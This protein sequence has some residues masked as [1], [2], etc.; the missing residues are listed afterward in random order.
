MS[1]VW[2]RDLVLGRRGCALLHNPYSPKIDSDDGIIKVYP[3]IQGSFLGSAKWQYN[4]Y[5]KENFVSNET[6]SIYENAPPN[7]IQKIKVG[8]VTYGSGANEKNPFIFFSLTNKSIVK[9]S[10]AT[11]DYSY[12]IQGRNDY[13][14]GWHDLWIGGYNSYNLKLYGKADYLYDYTPYGAQG[15]YLDPKTIPAVNSNPDWYNFKPVENQKV[16]QCYNAYAQ[17]N[18]LQPG[19]PGSSSWWIFEQNLYYVP[20]IQNENGQITNLGQCGFNVS[21]VRDSPETQIGNYDGSN[22]GWFKYANANSA[23]GMTQITS[24]ERAVLP[25]GYFYYV[26]PVWCSQS[27][28]QYNSSNIP[29]DLTF[30][31]P[32]FGFPFIMLRDANDDTQNEFDISYNSFITETSQFT[33]REGVS[34]SNAYNGAYTAFRTPNNETPYLMR[35]QIVKFDLNANLA[36]GCYDACWHKN[37]VIKIKLKYQLGEISINKKA[38]ELMAANEI[39]VGFSINYNWT[40]FVEE[41]V[42]NIEIQFDGENNNNFFTKAIWSKEIECSPGQAKRLVDICVLEVRDKT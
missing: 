30:P 19:Y 3:Y 35:N 17:P 34:P 4:D 2:F 37:K 31:L 24:N 41:E 21:V 12:S 9:T 39:N 27:G 42:D 33:N 13:F 11:W 36:F 20:A 32:E 28:T 25:G 29:Y 7:Y 23:A 40:D 22:P 26:R 15:I 10:F 5:G 1:F 8:E 6:G 38:G 18:P 16:V 14:G